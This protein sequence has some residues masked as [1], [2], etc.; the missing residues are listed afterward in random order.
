MKRNWIAWAVTMGE[1][2]LI[3]AA[4]VVLSQ[5]WLMLPVRLRFGAAFV[6][7]FAFAALVYRFYKFRRNQ[8][9]KIKTVTPPKPNE[10]ISVRC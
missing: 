8:P 4:A 1:G 9:R 5:Y 10:E 2:L 7:G 3:L 6:L